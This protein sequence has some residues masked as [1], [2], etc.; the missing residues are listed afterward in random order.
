L[1]QYEKA[2]SSKEVS[3]F[4]TEPITIYAYPIIAGHK[5][6]IPCKKTVNASLWEAPQCPALSWVDDFSSAWSSCS[7][8]TEGDCDNCAVKTWCEVPHSGTENST[9]FIS[10]GKLQLT[11]TIQPG[12]TESSSY[13]IY[14]KTQESGCN[15]NW[16]VEIDFSSSN[17][18]DCVL[19]SGY[20]NVV[21][22]EIINSTV[23]WRGRV[24][25]YV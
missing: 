4:H 7:Q 23:Y 6:S 8:T 13:R 1:D 16:Q 10:S 19:D 11:Q 17:W 15:N 21:I 12:P 9:P 14:T 25:F 3:N 22:Y 20:L 5:Q 2:Q 24:D 18:T